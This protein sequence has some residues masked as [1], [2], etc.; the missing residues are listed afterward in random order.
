MPYLPGR[1]PPPNVVLGHGQQPALVHHAGGLQ[2]LHRAARVVLDLTALGSLGDMSCAAILA[3]RSMA[4]QFIVRAALPAPR[5]HGP[6]G[7][8]RAGRAHPDLIPRQ[9]EQGH[10]A[11]F[12]GTHPAQPLV[13]GAAAPWLNQAS[14]APQDATVRLRPPRL[15]L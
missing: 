8:P 6:A 7:C 3:C 10:G 13:L 12:R 2:H 9:L 14:Q 5:G 11:T 15:A 1:L 4:E